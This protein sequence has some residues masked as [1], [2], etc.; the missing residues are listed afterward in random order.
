[1]ISKKC[2]KQRKILKRRV[3]IFYIN[4]KPIGAATTTKNGY[5]NFRNDVSHTMR[6]PQNKTEK[7]I[8]KNI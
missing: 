7:S 3:D 2:F 5:I 6:M 8:W 1:M 4:I